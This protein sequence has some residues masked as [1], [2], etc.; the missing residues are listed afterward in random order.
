AFTLAGA[1][2]VIVSIGIT[3]DTYIVLFERVQ[4]ETRQ[5]RSLANA[6]PRSFAMTWRTI[7]AANLVALISARLLS[8]LSV[9]AGTGFALRVAVTAMCGRRVGWC[10]IEPAVLLFATSRLAG[11]ARAAT[12]VPAPVGATA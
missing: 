7:V 5:G 3:A 8:W 10:F 4:D 2:G 9:G 12:G 11:D 6:V 1:T